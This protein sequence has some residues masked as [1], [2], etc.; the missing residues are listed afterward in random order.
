MKNK[1]YS[2]KEIVLEINKHLRFFFKE[3][4]KVL[5]KDIKE[6][7]MRGGKRLR[8][9]LVYYGYKLFSDNNKSDKE[10]IKMSIALELI[11]TFFLIHDDFMDKSNLRR[12]K[13]TIHEKYKDR[14]FAKITNL[15]EAM[16]YGDSI[17]VLAGDY[18][19]ML[20]IDAILSSSFSSEIKIKVIKKINEMISDTIVGQ[21]L[22][23]KIQSLKSSISEAD[24]LAMYKLKTAKY[25]FYYPLQIGA[26]LAESKIR[27][28]KLISD[29]AISCGIAYQIK[30]DIL[31]LFES[32]NTGKPYG[33]DVME[34]KKTLLIIKAY[35]KASKEEKRVLEKTLGNNRIKTKDINK[36]KKIIEK[37]G[38]YEYCMKKNS[39]YINKAKKALNKLAQKDLNKKVISHL[40]FLADF[41]IIRKH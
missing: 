2:F 7:C 39:E 3:K 19:H 22:D 9:A 26:I 27:Y 11:H 25:S 14:Y 36:V 10:I 37:T 13:K 40:E 20:G 34:G 31:D 4:N 35:E 12:R 21:E 8:P 6:C 30:D 41:S 16:H 23:I 33:L 5:E 32:K 17:A 38:A 1:I 28:E 18:S 29:Y 15:K 24:I